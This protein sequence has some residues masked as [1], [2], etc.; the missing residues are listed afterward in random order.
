MQKL[1][2]QVFGIS[3]D[4]F[5]AGRDQ[6]LDHPPGV[7]GMALDNGSS[8]RARLGRTTMSPAAQLD[9]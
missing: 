6:S 7:G 3:L 5:S 8:R 4:G 2:V 9:S 1:R